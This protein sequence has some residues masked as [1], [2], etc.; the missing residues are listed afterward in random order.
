MLFLLAIA[1]AAADCAEPSCSNAASVA[2]MQLKLEKEHTETAGWET[3][4]ASARLLRSSGIVI[5]PMLEGATMNLG[6]TFIGNPGVVLS[7]QGILNGF[8][9]VQINGG[10]TPPPGSSVGEMLCE[11]CLFAEGYDCLGDT[12]WLPSN[13]NFVGVTPGCYPPST[14]SGLDLNSPPTGNV[15]FRGCPENVA[16]DVA[17]NEMDSEASSTCVMDSCNGEHSGTLTVGSKTM[18]FCCPGEQVNPFTSLGLGYF[19]VAP[20]VEHG[21]PGVTCNGQGCTFQPQCACPQ[22]VPSSNSKVTGKPSIFPK[23]TVG[24][25]PPSGSSDIIIAPQ[26]DAASTFNA[27]SVFIGSP[28][29]AHAGGPQDGPWSVK[30]PPAGPFDGETIQITPTLTGGTTMHLGPVFVGSPGHIYKGDGA[31]WAIQT[32]PNVAVSP[33]MEQVQAEATG[34]AIKFY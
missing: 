3:H 30:A 15:N 31:D 25:G 16:T 24:L 29:S 17:W 28:D 7:P 22:A 9:T 10:P 34:G 6:E 4:N 11:G 13:C 12:A 19:G 2:L 20:T 32:A 5:D 33:V 14:S 26:L 1:V 23:E 8:S 18:T 27:Y 21:D